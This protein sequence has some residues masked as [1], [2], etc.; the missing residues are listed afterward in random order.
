MEPAEVELA[1]FGR[2]RRGRLGRNSVD[3]GDFKLGGNNGDG[4]IKE[5]SSSK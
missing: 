5:T 4:R 2:G 1:V 3:T